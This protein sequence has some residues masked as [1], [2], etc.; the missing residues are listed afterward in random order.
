MPLQGFPVSPRP[1]NSLVFAASGFRHAARAGLVWAACLVLA[2]GCAWGIGDASQ[3]EPGYTP[4]A[5]IVD[6]Q[7]D[8]R[9][10]GRFYDPRADIT[11][12]EAWVDGT[13]LVVNLV[14]AGNP[15]VWPRAPSDR[16]GYQVLLVPDD[17]QVGNHHNLSVDYD[18]SAWRLGIFGPNQ[19]GVRYTRT[20]FL[21][22]PNSVTMRVPLA[23]LQF[24]NEV[25]LF[26][27]SHVCNDSGVKCQGDQLPERADEFAPPDD[28]WLYLALGQ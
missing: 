2:G 19:D 20:G 1:G 5:R 12:L 9:V 8:T 16:P 22:G 18:A 7:G 27:F 14:L 3:A 4:A 26:A 24:P 13:N 15:D 23:E 6:A 10:P 25:R 28:S 17:E 11:A 21:L